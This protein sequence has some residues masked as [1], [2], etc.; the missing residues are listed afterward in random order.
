MLTAILYQIDALDN[1]FAQLTGF[2]LVVFSAAMLS[3]YVM[4][5]AAIVAFT[6]WFRPRLSRAV[7]R[8][9]WIIAFLVPIITALFPID[10]L[11]RLDTLGTGEHASL[12]QRVL[13]I[14][15]DELGASPGLQ[16]Q[17]QLARMIVG[18]EYFINAVLMVVLVLL[19]IIPGT[20]RAGIRIK[21]LLPEQTM[22]GWFLVAAPLFSSLLLLPLF[23]AVNQIASDLFLIIGTLLLM[24]APGVYLAGAG[25]FI[26]PLQLP[27]GCRRIGRVQGL[28]LIVGGL[29]WT[30]LL[31]YAMTRKIPILDKTLI[32]LQEETSLL[33]P[34]EWY[35]FR[36][37]IEYTGRSLYTTIVIADL[38]LVVGLAVWQD[39]IQSAHAGIAS[40]QDQRMSHL[41]QAVTAR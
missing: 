11:I 29:A 1:D 22:T 14:L 26:R 30:L 16:G 39:T 2:G 28:A 35:L 33:R 18:I 40:N 8:Y 13:R 7:M 17:L 34:W 32:G 4:P 31:A 21:T 37:L 12:P 36:S 23:I 41:R 15:L 3:L 9:G 25:V 38:L 24:A 20:L 10:W 6:C 19:T 27:E 5:L